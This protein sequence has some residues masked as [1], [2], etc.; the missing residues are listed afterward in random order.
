M[1]KP[2]HYTKLP[3]HFRCETSNIHRLLPQYP[4]LSYHGTH[5]PSSC[6]R[7]RQPNSDTGEIVGLLVANIPVP[8][9]M[10]TSTERYS[11]YHD[12]KRRRLAAAYRRFGKL[13][14][15]GPVLSFSR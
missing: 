7:L 6:T 4:T 14:R 5:N 9:S 12:A 15:S 10:Q 1:S 11:L 2:R 8:N 3:S 13:I